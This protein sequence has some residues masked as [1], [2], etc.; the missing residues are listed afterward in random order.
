MFTVFISTSSEL[1]PLRDAIHDTLVAAGVHAVTQ[2]KSLGQSPRDVR[3]L[4]AKD[5]EYSDIVIHIAG[6]Q[7]GA[8]AG[9]TERPA[10]PDFPSFRCSWTQFE[11][12][13]AHQ[14][15]KDVYAF[16]M[17]PGSATRTET[18]SNNDQLAELQH[19]IQQAHRQRII[20]GKFEG[21]PVHGVR[22]T[23]NDSRVVT[24]DLDML[25][26]L[27]GVVRR[28]QQDWGGRKDKIA[29]KLD[30][31]T[32]VLAGLRQISEEQKTLLSEVHRTTSVELV[33]TRRRGKYVTAALIL[34]LGPVLAIALGGGLAEYGCR[35]PW[36]KDICIE[37]NWGQT[38]SN[39][40]Q[41]AV[42]EILH[43]S[44][45]EP[46][47]S[48]FYVEVFSGNPKSINIGIGNS[49]ISPLNPRIYFLKVGAN[50]PIEVQVPGY[51]QIDSLDKVVLLRKNESG[52]FEIVRDFTQEVF[53]ALVDTTLD[54]WKQQAQTA[55]GLPMWVCT[56]GG[57]EI[58]EP[59]GAQQ[60]CHPALSKAELAH[61]E[62]AWFE[63]DRSHCAKPEEQH[64]IC[65]DFRSLPFQIDH[66]KGFKARFTFADGRAVEYPVPLRFE[67]EYPAADSRARFWDKAEPIASR[68]PPGNAPLLFVDFHGM[69]WVLKSG[70]D[71]CRG[72]VYSEKG[73]WLVDWDSKGLM[74]ADQYD[75]PQFGP[76]VYQYDSRIPKDSEFGRLVAGGEGMVGIAL[77]R[78]AGNRLGPYW[79]RFDPREAVRL[80]S[81]RH[82]ESLAGK[83]PEVK[84]ITPYNAPAF[85]RPK[86]VLEWIEIKSVEF[87][88][89]SANLDTTIPLNIGV[90]DFL[91]STCEDN[92]Q[93]CRE[94]NYTIPVNATDVYY[95]V[96]DRESKASDVIRINLPNRINMTSETSDSPTQ[97]QR[98]RW[99]Q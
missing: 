83:M 9:S 36:V 12:Y 22:R 64:P 94:F 40:A 32:R 91:A 4:L 10:F 19:H 76:K 88:V 59:P 41:E 39:K 61:G 66:T 47:A 89:E 71:A 1:K 2:D 37:R 26:R 55:M 3:D 85:C 69:A 84:C 90:E 52:E 56:I 16:V 15:G 74:A 81:R 78:H 67:R 53:K 62:G 27:A 11:Y 97:P 8:D 30:A 48:S 49:A 98:R 99:A 31:Q 58:N 75:A 79:Y 82:L 77:E 42:S 60:L 6:D 13:Y 24:G 92:G 46:A 38:S 21:T 35:L 28:G 63:L 93:P 72:D 73:R 18:A 45:K 34:V 96:I 33:Q 5:I 50:S 87:G 65:V 7:Y 17:A 54:H 29:E 44:T 80:A 51:S 14:L 43:L 57:C 20:S 86:S 23:L 68:N 25:S 95:R 70:L